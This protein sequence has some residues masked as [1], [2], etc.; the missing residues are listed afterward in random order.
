MQKFCTPE[1]QQEESTDEQCFYDLSGI[2]CH[3][4]GTVGAGHY[5]SYNYDST[6]RRWYHYNDSSVT[7]VTEEQVTRCEP[8][9]LLYEQHPTSTTGGKDSNA[10]TRTSDNDVTN[11]EGG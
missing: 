5:T 3:H 7:S 10:E 11:V 1:W 4:G 6:T 9:I 8:Y 2:V